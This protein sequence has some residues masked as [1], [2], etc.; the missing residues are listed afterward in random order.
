MY[1]IATE[2][3]NPHFRNRTLRSK[4]KIALLRGI[5]RPFASHL[6]QFDNYAAHMSPQSSLGS[7]HQPEF[8]Q[9]YD[10]PLFPTEPAQVRAQVR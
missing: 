10:S 3:Q 6:K 5:V 8:M 4:Y 9:Q 7:L 1:H 2:I